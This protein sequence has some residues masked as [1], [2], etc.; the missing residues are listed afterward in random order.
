MRRKTEPT[1]L[2]FMGKGHDVRSVCPHLR[3]E[4]SLKGP[5]CEDEDGWHADH[6]G[7]F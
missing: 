7:W 5:L 6:R 2:G 1:S 4:K 3:S